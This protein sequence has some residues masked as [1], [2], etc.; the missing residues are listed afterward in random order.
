MQSKNIIIK[1]IS[2]DDI[3]KKD[4]IWIKTGDT[5]YEYLQNELINV[6]FPILQ[7]EDKELLLTS[8]IRVINLIYLK[9]GFWKNNDKDENLLWDQLKQN[10]RLRLKS[11]INNHSSVHQ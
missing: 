8:L 3:E 10:Q 1:N 2:W 7:A 5:K 9:F 4:Y 6:V 11:P